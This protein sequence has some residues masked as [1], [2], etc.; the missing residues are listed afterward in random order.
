MRVTYD[1]RDLRTG[2][3]VDFEAGSYPVMDL[4]KEHR[5]RYVMQT[6]RGAIVLRHLPLRLKRIIDTVRRELYPSVHDLEQRARDLMPYFD[7]IPQDQWPQDKVGELQDIERQ[8]QVTDMYALG[9]IE[10][11][12]LATM[13]D[14][15]TL[16][17]MLTDDERQ[18]LAVAVRAL[19]QVKPPDHVDGTAMDIAQRYGMRV[20]DEDML[21]LMTVSQA[22][23]LISRIE[24]ENREIMRLRTGGEEVRRVRRWDWRSSRISA[25]CGRSRRPTS[26]R[27]SAG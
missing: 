27:A 25:G 3:S 8:L 5:V 6:S 10:A 26:H 1:Y 24:R 14:Y 13:D 20:M 9:V 4:L 16:V 21:R 17:E 18:Q 2:E 23:Y 11:P 12:L 7:G 22:N 19:S 15:D